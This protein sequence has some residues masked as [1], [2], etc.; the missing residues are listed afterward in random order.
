[1]PDPLSRADECKRI[2]ELHRRNTADIELDLE[3]QFKTL[4][5]RAQVLL[6]ICGVLL[7]ASIV[8]TAGRI[9]GQPKFSL[10]HL[11][12]FLLA[13]AGLADVCATAAVV[14]GVLTIRWLT[15]LGGESLEV[16]VTNAIAYRDSKTSAYRAALRLVL[17]S[18]LLYQVAVLIVVLQL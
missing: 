15:Q 14:G 2:I 13:I 12:G 1:V 11:A 5:N 9:I 17:L 18:M 16:W 8:I 6:A 4:H 7:S 3:R 10:E